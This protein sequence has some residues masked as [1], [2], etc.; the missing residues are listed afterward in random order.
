MQ[1]I[2]RLRTLCKNHRELMFTLLI[3]LEN[4]NN[5]YMVKTL[6]HLLPLPWQRRYFLLKDVYSIM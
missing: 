2:D 3:I 5:N 4:N 6:L 1:A